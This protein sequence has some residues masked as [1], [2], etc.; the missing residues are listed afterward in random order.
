MSLYCYFYF[1]SP[2][3]AHSWVR[4]HCAEAHSSSNTAFIRVSDN[5]ESGE[6][7]L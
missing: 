7:R 5:E 4:A 6:R 3:G 1:D 2:Y